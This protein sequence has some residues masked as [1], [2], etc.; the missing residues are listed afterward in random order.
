MVHSSSQ[1]YGH[2]SRLV[3]WSV[4]PSVT[5]FFYGGKREYDVWLTCLGALGRWLACP[6]DPHARTLKH[7]CTHATHTRSIRNY[8]TRAGLVF[9][10]TI[11]TYMKF[12][13]KEMDQKKNL[14][15]T[16]NFAALI[17]REYDYSIKW[18]KF[19]SVQYNLAIKDLMELSNI[20]FKCL[21]QSVALQNQKEMLDQEQRE[22]RYCESFH[23]SGPLL[24]GSAV[25]ICCSIKLS[26]DSL[27]KFIYY[28]LKRE[29]PIS[30]LSSL[31]ELF[32]PL[33]TQGYPW[34][35]IRSLNASA[36]SFD[37][38]SSFWHWK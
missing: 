33:Q 34:C 18:H 12:K 36:F 25:Y 24:R 28:W 16:S 3:L 2:G 30:I 32:S 5:R 21:D 23:S 10:Q 4:G 17:G 35:G 11:T 27:I 8:W 37:K 1:I 13:I 15:P 9:T 6:S 19:L 7:T 22:I 14:V 31:Q 29:K 26:L 38:W 20:I